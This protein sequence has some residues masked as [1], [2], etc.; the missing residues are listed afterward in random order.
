MNKTEQKIEEK[1][2]INKYREKK[3]RRKSTFKFVVFV[4]IVLVIILIVANWRTVFAPFEGMW[5]KRGEGGF[6]VSLPGSTQYYLGEMGEYFY[7]L[8]DTYLYTYNKD[9]AEIA[10]IQH[11]FQNPASVSNDRRIMVYDKNGRSFRMY[12]RSGEVYSNSVED[13]IVFGQIGN[14]ERSAIVTTSTRYSNYLC[15][16]NAEGRQIF[17]WASP[18]EKIMGVCFG[19]GDN[20]VYVSVVGEK[21]GQLRGSIVKFD[22][23]G[24]S[25]TEAEVW[26]TSIGEAVTYSLEL[27]S[28]GVYVVTGSGAMVLNE[29]TGEITATGTFTMSINSIPDF[30]G[31]RAV[32]FRDSASNKKTAVTF[33]EALKPVNSVTPD[34]DIAACDVSGGRLYLLVGNRLTVYDRS[35]RE[36]ASYE[37]DDEYSNF[38]IINGCAYLLG[39]NT[40]QRMKL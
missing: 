11:Q 28:E 1:N 25:G 17:R 12:S 18:D 4:A 35:L 39:Y 33:D 34:D 10:G 16:F 15:V 40:V 30:D 22:L 9:G 6:P 7:L 27:S 26:R 20:S 24:N 23:T 3:K 8:T 29:R 32:I 2:D 38:K 31:L 5:L 37:L 21:N 19:N 13:I 14:V 36:T